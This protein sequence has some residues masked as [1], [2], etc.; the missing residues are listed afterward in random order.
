M[1]LPLH[2][3]SKLDYLIPNEIIKACQLDQFDLNLT[4]TG[5]PSF[6]IYP[7]MRVWIDDNIMWDGSVVNQQSIPIS[8]KLDITRQS[9]VV[10]IE[11]YNKDEIKGTCVNEEGKVVENQS[12]AI[13]K[14]LLNSVDLVSNNSIYNFGYYYM[15]LSD[16]KCK[17]FKEHGYNIGPNHSLNMFENGEWKLTFG[18]PITRSIAKVV[19]PQRTT[20]KWPDNDL[21]IDII[22]TCDRINQLQERLKHES[23]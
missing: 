3:S 6:Q 21:L 13:D 7:K 18:I 11:Y 20:T 15:K 10:R 16:S 19:S 2:L 17:Y 4:V 1:K 8:H 14:F 22:N 23:N 12:L 9:V 5:T